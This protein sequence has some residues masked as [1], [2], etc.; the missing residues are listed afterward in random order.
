MNRLMKRCVLPALV[1]VAAG[2]VASCG[3]SAP[4]APTTTGPG[5]LPTFSL[6]GSVT[7]NVSVPIP[8]AEVA[9]VGGTES[10]LTDGAGRY[11]LRGLPGGII[12][13]RVSKEGYAPWTTNIELPRNVPTH[14]MLIFTG[15]SVDLAGNYTV[16]FTADA[17][18]TQLPE[19]TRTRT[20]TA[21]VTPTITN[22]YVFS[23][24]GARFHKNRFEA[25][26]AR[27]SASFYTVQDG[28]DSVVHERLGDSR[29]VWIDF[30]ARADAVDAPTISVPIFGNYAFCPDD[31]LVTTAHCLVPRITCTSSNHTLTMTRR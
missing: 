10:T 14:F 19:F 11:E 22:H 28:Y 17:A 4:T 9:I 27:R 8:G 13:V 2:L 31:N 1:S 20:Y 12:P 16:T 29:S 5:A 21:S 18:C 3:P 30:V 26:V 25:S 23:L 7:D 6:S 15:P 24:S